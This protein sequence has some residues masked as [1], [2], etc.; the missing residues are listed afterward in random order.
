[1][2]GLNPFAKPKTPA[3]PAPTPLPVP[4]DSLLKQK[5]RQDAARRALLGS[6]ASTTGEG[7]Q[8]NTTIGM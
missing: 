2:G 3:I 4:D 6:R 1:M 5:K 8:N 7:Q